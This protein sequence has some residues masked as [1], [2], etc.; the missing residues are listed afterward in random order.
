MQPSTSDPQRLSLRPFRPEDQD[1]VKSLIL[2]GLKEHWGT[3]DPSLNPDLDDIATSYKDAVFLVACEGDRIIG[4]PARHR[5]PHPR[6]AHRRRARARLCAH[7]PGDH[8]DLGRRHRLLP[9]RRIRDHAPPGWECVLREAPHPA[10]L[11]GRFPS[12]PGRAGSAAPQC[13]SCGA[14]APRPDAG[15]TAIAGTVAGMPRPV[16][17]AN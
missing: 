8:R 17:P 5:A 9:G 10:P 1:A 2:A 4:T 3:L 14:A 13:G 12:T 15:P 11:T 6:R 7:H 16:A